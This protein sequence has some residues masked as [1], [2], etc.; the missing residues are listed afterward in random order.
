MGSAEPTAGDLPLREGER[1]RR[2]VPDPGGSESSNRGQ[3]SEE[4]LRAIYGPAYVEEYARR[5]KR[6]KRRIGNILRHV[7]LGPQDVVGDFG[8]GNGVLAELVCS[9]VRTYLG[10]DFSS[11]FI[12][13]ARE[14]K[15]VRDLEN[16]TFHCEDIV[17]FC[18]ARPESFDKAFALDFTE[19]LYDETLLDVLRAVRESLR[20]GGAL[21]L[22]TPNGRFVLEI[23]KTRGFLRQIEGHVAVR[24]EEQYADL[25]RTAGFRD[26]DVSHLPHYIKPLAALHLLSRL[27]LAGRYL[28]ARLLIRCV[29]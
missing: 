19:H 22:H 8:C 7:A 25:L 21:Y 9:E 12:R 10:V 27:P 24:S 5:E 17:S 6:Q 15:R 2:A 20:P 29:R 23:L 14:R 28:R 26:V 3:L 16:A 11:E 1:D 4:E 18:R 13:H